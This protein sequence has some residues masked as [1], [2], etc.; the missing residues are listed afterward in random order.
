MKASGR[1]CQ[2]KRLAALTGMQE[3]LTSEILART[4]ALRQVML[5]ML[6]AHPRPDDPEARARESSP[7][8]DERPQPAQPAV[9]PPPAPA[10]TATPQEYG[11]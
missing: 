5:P 4:P 6:Y 7:R 10:G 3:A 11:P 9:E 1:Q 8:T 2:R